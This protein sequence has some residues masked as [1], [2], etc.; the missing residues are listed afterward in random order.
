MRANVEETSGGN[1]PLHLGFI[2]DADCAPIVLAHESGLFDKYELNVKLHRETGWGNI[3][4]KVTQGDLDAAH[5][6]VTFP[7]VTSLGIESD[8]CACVTGMVLSLQGNG[9][10]LSRRLWDEG[11][12]DAKTLRD[13]IY[14]NW[15][16]RTCTF[17]I[18]FPNSSPHFLLRQ[19]LAMGGVAADT[20]VR[21]VALPPWQMFPMLKLGY[22]DGFCAGEP[23]TSLAA[24]TQLGICVA[25][26]ADL[27]PLHPEKVLMV[28]REFAATRAAEHER[29][30][31]ALIEA[32]AFCDQPKNRPLLAEMLAQ[33][34]YVNAPVECLREGLKISYAEGGED[35][36]D[37]SSNIFRRFNA[38]EPT[39][40]KAG[41]VIGHLSEAIEQS[42]S[43]IPP[44]EQMVILKD[45]FRPDIFARAKAV[46]LRQSRKLEVEAESY[47]PGVPA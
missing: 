30:I 43:G 12:R 28:R 13:L 31:A 29:L 23:W 26:S 19:W 16:K 21:I 27:A 10:T 40:D 41:W 25:T 9:I 8:P 17:G 15:G 7:F 24:E 4:D 3:R 32:C 5:A 33:P 22:I 35:S 34:H 2:P 44:N 1:K 20:E 42:V 45:I 39:E 14:H 36:S 11:V 38:N 6:P 37:I 46:M 47:R 18:V